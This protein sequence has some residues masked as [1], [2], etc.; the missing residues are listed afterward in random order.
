[1]L[2]SN[3]FTYRAILLRVVMKGGSMQ[4]VNEEKPKGVKIYMLSL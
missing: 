4:L 1:M 3:S 2:A